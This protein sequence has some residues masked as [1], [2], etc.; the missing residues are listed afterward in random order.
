MLYVNSGTLSNLS[1]AAAIGS[2][3][4]SYP[5]MPSASK[6]RNSSKPASV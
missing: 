1:A 6:P 2:V 3:T 4:G 5:L